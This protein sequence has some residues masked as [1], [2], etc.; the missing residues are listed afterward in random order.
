MRKHLELLPPSDRSAAMG[1]LRRAGFTISP[2]TSGPGIARK[3]AKALGVEVPINITEAAILVRQ[4]VLAKEVPSGYGEVK[5]WVVY[6]QPLAMTR[7]LA[8]AANP[9]ERQPGDGR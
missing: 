4:Y 7:A 2:S 3:V 9:Y 8:R 5:N 1:K 6:T